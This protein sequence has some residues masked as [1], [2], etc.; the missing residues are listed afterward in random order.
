MRII[1]LRLIIRNIR[2][3]Y[4]SHKK[5]KGLTEQEYNKFARNSFSEII[6]L[7]RYLYLI[8]AVIYAPFMGIDLYYFFTE[9][10]GN[11]RMVLFDCFF[12]WLISFSSFC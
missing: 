12:I 10:Y 6:I 2:H 5:V 8:L 1:L 9:N 11:L 3:F 7:L 4:E